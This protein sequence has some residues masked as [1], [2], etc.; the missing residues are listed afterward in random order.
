MGKS[1]NSGPN[2]PPAP[3]PADLY[4]KFTDLYL[5]NQGRFLGAEDTARTG[6]DPARIQHQQD[7][8][9]QFGPEQYQQILEAFGQLDPQYAAAHGALGDRVT[10]D[11][12]TGGQYAGDYNSLINQ[13]KGDLAQ[14]Y[15]I[16]P[17]QQ[18]EVEQGLRGSQAARGNASGTSAGVAEAY[19]LG[20]KG[21]QM[22]QQRLGNYQSALGQGA[23]YNQQGISNAG[24]FLGS[25]TIGQQ[26]SFIPPVSPDRS[27]AY[28]NPNAGF[29]GVTLGNQAYANN[30][31]AAGANAQGGGNPWMSAIGAAGSIFGGLAASGAFSDRRLKTDIKKVG[32]DEN[33]LNLYEF[34]YKSPQ[35]HIGYMA[36]EVAK[37]DPDAVFKDPAS[38]YFKVTQEYAP[39]E[40][41]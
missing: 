8:Q 40:V 10:N 39:V 18:R 7:L 38:G 23:Q 35:K 33:G 1:G 31:A 36:Q 20:D 22:Y 2:I 21:A 3:N 6:E 9:N 19:A 32:K 24:G 16:S 17:S 41:S 4:K 13:T 25:P 26:A 30:V 11:L 34:A 12:T 15:N 28:I 14:G 5:N 37:A 27:F 29:Q